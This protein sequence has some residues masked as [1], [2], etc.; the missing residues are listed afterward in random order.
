MEKPARS[1]WAEGFSSAGGAA[2][3]AAAAIEPPPSN[4]LNAC[5]SD[6]ASLC[7]DLRSA[8]SRSLGP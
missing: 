7:T 3:A 8:L 4:R 5:L 2:L 1:L 6:L